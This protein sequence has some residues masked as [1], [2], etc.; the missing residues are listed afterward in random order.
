[1][2]VSRFIIMRCGCAG[3]YSTLIGDYAPVNGDHEPGC[4]Q[5]QQRKEDAQARMQSSLQAKEKL[6]QSSLYRRPLN[7]WK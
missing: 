5:N 2:Q 4:R 3:E 1:M 7:L 6:D